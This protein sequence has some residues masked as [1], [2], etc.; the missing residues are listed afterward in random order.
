MLQ[1][2][3]FNISNF[4]SFKERKNSTQF[5]ELNSINVITGEN[6]TGK[7]NVLRA[8]NMFFKPELYDPELDRNFINRVTGGATSKPSFVISLYDTQTKASAQIKLSFNKTPSNKD[9]PLY[10]YT[11][12]KESKGNQEELIIHDQTSRGI[13]RFLDDNFK[14]VYL[15]A[16]DEPMSEQADIVLNNMILSYYKK[17]NKEIKKSVDDFEKAYNNLISN[18]SNNLETL[19]SG[20]KAKFEDLPQTFYPELSLKKEKTITD[21]LI[22][23]FQLNINDTYAQNLKVKGSGVQRS[24]IILMN[25]FLVDNIYQDQNTIILVDEPEAFLYPTLVEAI[26]KTL[27]TIVKNNEQMQLFITTHSPEF[28][29]E[30]NN[31]SYSFYNLS[32][33][34]F[35]KSFQRSSKEED[36]VKYSII[37]RYTSKIKNEILQKYGLLDSIDNYENIIIVEGPSDKNYL[38]KTLLESSNRPQIRTSTDYKDIDGISSGASGIVPIL[39][40]LDAV[41]EV[42]RNINVILDG[43]EEGKKT[44]RKINAEKRIKKKHNIKITNLDNEKSIEDYFYDKSS[45]TKKVI[46]VVNAEQLIDGFDE[47]QFAQTME[48]ST[49]NIVESIRNYFRMKGFSEKGVLGR[50]KY[51]LSLT[52]KN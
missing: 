19:S 41:S 2:N 12:E 25:L 21:F 42:T 49:Q 51:E 47:K 4:R 23:N 46:Q 3:G 43:D 5:S 9:E 1:I 44:A 40:Y 8:L 16:V 33:D 22:D 20:M 24:S 37:S 52:C 7:T 18:L 29:Q 17:Q 36:V 39:Y 31:P 27:Q 45:V 13:K 26:K 10:T 50:I 14:V 48:M 38:I 35:N 30:T 15:S 32:Q 6:N 28:I 11:V 34:Q